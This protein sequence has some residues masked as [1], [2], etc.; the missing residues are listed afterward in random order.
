MV[1][2]YFKIATTSFRKKKNLSRP[3]EMKTI[4]WNKMLCWD[5][6]N[7]G[8]YAVISIPHLLK[9]QKLTMKRS[10]SMN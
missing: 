2:F 3:N 6:R 1:L 5:T 4:N 9:G 7:N 10:G 8:T